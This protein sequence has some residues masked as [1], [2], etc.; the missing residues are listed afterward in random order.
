MI[1]LLNGNLLCRDIILQ[2]KRNDS[3]KREILF[4]RNYDISVF[5]CNN[6]C[7]KVIYCNDNNR[8]KVYIASCQAMLK[9]FYQTIE[10]TVWLQSRRFVQQHHLFEILPL[11]H[12]QI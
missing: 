5:V 11:S 12:P 4:F 1:I 8:L 7:P 9:L 6:F 2:T 3:E 10:T